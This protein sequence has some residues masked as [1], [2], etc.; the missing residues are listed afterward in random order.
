[1]SHIVVPAAVVNIVIAVNRR[2]KLKHTNAIARATA[3][4]VASV[5]Q[6]HFNLLLAQHTSATMYASAIGNAIF[7]KTSTF[8]SR[9]S[10]RFITVRHRV[11][12][13][14]GVWTVVTRLSRLSSRPTSSA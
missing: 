4:D 3:R 10:S 9:R 7:L 1:M 13:R 11:G 8:S 5:F 14:V 2:V 6:I 12:R